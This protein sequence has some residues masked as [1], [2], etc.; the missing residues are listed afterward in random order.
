MTELRISDVHV[1][2]PARVVAILNQTYDTTW[3]DPDQSRS[4]H[5]SGQ[6]PN[7]DQQYFNKLDSKDRGI[8]AQILRKVG[9]QN[10]T[11]LSNS[12]HA[13]GDVGYGLSIQEVLPLRVD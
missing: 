3:M 1:H 10:M 7:D 6:C 13:L 5:G 11:L 4:P 12:S 8:G 9:V 2:A